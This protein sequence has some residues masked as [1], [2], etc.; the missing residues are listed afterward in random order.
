MRYCVVVL[1]LLLASCNK[2]DPNPELKDPIYLDL[3]KRVKEMEGQITEEGKTLEEHKGALAKVLPQT[4]QN[5]YAQKRVFDSENRIEHLKQLKKY[6]EISSESRKMKD[7]LEYSRS[8]NKGE[9]WP[10]SAE[11]KDYMDRRK[12]DVIPRAWNYKARV[13]ELKEQNPPSKP[14][15]GGH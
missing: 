10:D 2:P 15:G 8:M 5:K 6:L 3:L 9:P 14:A 7:A 12:G 1:L 11:F 13:E 4:G